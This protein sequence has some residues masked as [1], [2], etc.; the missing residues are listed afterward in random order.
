[1]FFF[2]LLI[3]V[4]KE[5]ERERENLGVPRNDV[6]FICYNVVFV[7]ARDRFQAVQKQIKRSQAKYYYYYYYCGVCCTN[8]EV[9]EEQAEVGNG[10]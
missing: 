3:V 2:F 5:R 1:M 7:Q 4:Y 6:L 8:P 10:D 9:M